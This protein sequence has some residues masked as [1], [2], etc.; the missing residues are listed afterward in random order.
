MALQMCRRLVKN[1]IHCK[2]P[3]NH[4]TSI[5]ITNLSGKCPSTYHISIWSICIIRLSSAI[6]FIPKKGW[7]ENWWKIKKTLP[8]KNHFI[9]M[10]KIK[11]Q[12]SFTSFRCTTMPIP[13][14]RILTT[15]SLH[16]NFTQAVC[17]S[18]SSKKKYRKK[19]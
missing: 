8:T 1:I 3:Q 15:V 18:Y 16:L 2:W 5:A 14:M 19:I 17:Y 11:S 7:R 9:A 6:W 12:L 4:K 10:L 13:T